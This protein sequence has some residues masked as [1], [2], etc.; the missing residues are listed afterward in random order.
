VPYEK[1]DIQA[2]YLATY[3]PHYYQLIYK[4]FIE[5]VPDIF[6]NKKE[7]HLTFIGGGPGSEAYGA[8]NYIFNNCPEANN[9]FI[10]LSL[11]INATTWDYSHSI[12]LKNCDRCY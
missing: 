2:A 1:T 8:L 11:D 5:E 9:V 3:L 7:I 10:S 6:K 12:V 4:I